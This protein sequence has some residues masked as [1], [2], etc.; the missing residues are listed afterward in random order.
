MCVGGVAGTSTER[1]AV[2]SAICR[3]PAAHAQHRRPGRLGRPA[4][5][6]GQATTRG[7]GGHRPRCERVDRPPGAPLNPLTVCPAAPGQGACEVVSAQRTCSA[8]TT[9]TGLCIAKSCVI[10]HPMLG[11]CTRARDVAVASLS[12]PHTHT[13]ARASTRRTPHRARTTTRMRRRMPLNS[14]QPSRT[15]S[16][17]TTLRSRSR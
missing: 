15:R 16:S 4:R 14:S 5:K 17:S 13:H 9:Q 7:R 6:G 1:A 3:I 12:P 11:G 2:G 8:P 10:A